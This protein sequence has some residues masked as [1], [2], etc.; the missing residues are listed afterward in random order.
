MSVYYIL[1]VAI[2]QIEAP[3]LIGAAGEHKGASARRVEP[4]LVRRKRNGLIRCFQSGAEIACHHQT[5]GHAANPAGDKAQIVLRLFVGGMEGNEA[6]RDGEAV[7][8]RLQ[9][10]RQV[11]CTSPTLL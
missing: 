3:R 1:L 6:L 9:R 4:Y 10:A 5:V 2:L 11:T 7:T 8:I